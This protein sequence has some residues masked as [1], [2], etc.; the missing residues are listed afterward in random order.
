ME[1]ARPLDWLTAGFYFTLG[2]AAAGLLIFII[3]ALVLILV[4]HRALGG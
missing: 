3:V 4:F 2:A 1:D